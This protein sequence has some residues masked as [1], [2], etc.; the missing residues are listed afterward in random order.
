MWDDRY[1]ADEY[2]YGTE[3]NKFLKERAPS[4][5][6]G[7]RVLCLADGEG[8]NSVHLASLGY[9]VVGVDASEVGLRKA[10][11]LAEEAGVVC[12]YEH[13]DLASYD[14]GKARWD[15][16]VS[17]SCHLPPDIRRRVHEASVAA[18][19][20]GGVFMLEAYTPDQIGRGTGGPTD[21]TFMM[22]AA[23]LEDELRGLKFEH[24]RELEREVIEGAYHTGL[25]SVVQAVARRT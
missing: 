7:G 17:I 19:R 16:I 2:I 20:P 18:L 13:A 15:G 10:H 21:A 24:L 9:H 5:P 22:T 3:P 11:K 14:L 4:I 8:R 12:T 6:V 23:R 1:N 25:A